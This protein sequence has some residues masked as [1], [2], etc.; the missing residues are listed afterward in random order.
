MF[1]IQILKEGVLE[2]KQLTKPVSRNQKK[3]HT[4][5]T[6]SSIAPRDK[7][8]L[9]AELADIT[10]QLFLIGEEIA[11]KESELSRLQGNLQSSQKKV[12]CAAKPMARTIQNATSI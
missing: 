5:E 9:K 2:I 10:H 6:T 12:S 7:K 3:L 4:T 1:M 8:I 11:S